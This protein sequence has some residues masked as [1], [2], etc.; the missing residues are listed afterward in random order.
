MFNI[1][2]LLSSYDYVLVG[3]RVSILLVKILRTL[4]SILVVRASVPMYL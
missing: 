4:K 2:I 1:Q 3:V